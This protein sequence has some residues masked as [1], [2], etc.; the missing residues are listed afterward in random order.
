M[1]FVGSTCMTVMAFV[2][3][4][5]KFIAFVLTKSLY[6]YSI[7]YNMFKPYDFYTFPKQPLYRG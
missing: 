2:F 3:E 7:H 4:H 5:N 1:S 6:Q